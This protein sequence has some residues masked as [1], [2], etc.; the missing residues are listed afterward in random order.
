VNFR[1]N[2]DFGREFRFLAC[3]RVI[4]FVVAVIAAL[5]LRSSWA[6]VIGIFAG[7]TA[8]VILSYLMEPF[9]PRPSLAA[10]RQM[11]SFSG[12]ML[13]V[14]IA[15]AVIGKIPL[16]FVGRM[17]GA[18]TLGAYTVGAEIAQLAHTE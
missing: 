4:S 8:G 9:R 5:T 1:R 16:F 15:S 2:M 14:N 12:W 7:G 6:P 3:K 10:S 17:F 13:V 18:Q 11:F